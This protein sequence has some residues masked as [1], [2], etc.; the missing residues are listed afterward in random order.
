MLDI[1]VCNVVGAE[2]VW[3]C[4]SVGGWVSLVDCGWLCGYG[5][6]WIWWSVGGCV[7]IV[8]CGWSVGGCVDI[9]V[10]G[11]LCESGGWA[12]GWIVIG[13]MSYRLSV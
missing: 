5:G 10:C 4:W 13:N 9:V 2:V 11:W 7:D 3:I 1:E 12:V 8:V 6:L